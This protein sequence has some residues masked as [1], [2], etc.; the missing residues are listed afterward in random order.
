MLLPLHSPKPSTCPRPL[1]R[2]S[3]W[4]LR[5]TAPRRRPDLPAGEQKDLAGRCCLAQEDLFAYKRALTTI[6]RAWRTVVARPPAASTL[7][8]HRPAGSAA[9]HRL[10]ADQ[11]KPIMCPPAAEQG[12]NRTRYKKNLQFPLAHLYRGTFEEVL[13]CWF[14][15]ESSTSFMINDFHYAHRIWH[16]Y[17]YRCLTQLIGRMRSMFELFVNYLSNK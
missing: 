3:T 11:E 8:G 13:V 10:T 14:H 5:M 15:L 4:L 9:Q 2:Q 7:P 16:D 17:L 12:Q 1:L 6:G